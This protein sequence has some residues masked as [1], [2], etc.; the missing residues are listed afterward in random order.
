[1]QSVSTKIASSLHRFD[2]I[3]IC[4]VFTRAVTLQ[5]TCM[6]NVHCANT[7]RYTHHACMGC[8]VSIVNGALQ[9]Q[10]SVCKR[11]CVW[12]DGGNVPHARLQPD[13]PSRQ[14]VCCLAWRAGVAH[15][16]VRDARMGDP[17]ALYSWVYSPQRCTGS[18]DLLVAPWCSHCTAVV[19]RETHPSPVQK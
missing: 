14:L 6:Y 12:S 2:K 7:R 1:M 13:T 10:L 4:R 8:G 17:A 9:G 3:Q 5:E 19:A 16:S 15:R 18:A 11:I